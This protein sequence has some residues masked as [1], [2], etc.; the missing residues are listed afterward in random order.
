MYD[1]V[2]QSKRRLVRKA[3]F[4]CAR[5]DPG[6][7]NE[8]RHGRAVGLRQTRARVV[9]RR[10]LA[11]TDSSRGHD[12][13]VGRAK[14]PG[15][16][17]EVGASPL[18]RQRAELIAVAT[19]ARRTKVKRAIGVGH[20]P[21]PNPRIRCDGRRLPPARFRSGNVAPSSRL[22]KVNPSAL[23]ARMIDSRLSTVFL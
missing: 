17:I 2:R 1:N 3:D 4:G 14:R 22:V 6:R 7:S 11:H 23:R 16:T 15:F 10:H 5:R 18:A 8:T 19:P 12:A 21:I 9:L 13:W 20:A